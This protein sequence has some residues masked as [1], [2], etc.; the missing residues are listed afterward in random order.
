MNYKRL[1]PVITPAFVWGLSQV[2]F[3]RP[4]FFFAALALGTLLIAW[5]VKEIAGRHE[6]DWYFFISAPILFSLAFN[7]YAAVIASSFLVQVCFVAIAWFLYSYLK[8]FYHFAV[9]KEER[10][11]WKIRLHRL[12]IPGGFLTMFA[13]FAVMLYLP[14]FFNLDI[15][16]SLPL[17]IVLSWLLFVQFGPIKHI[18][19]RPTGTLVI[20]NVIIMAEMAWAFTLL[21]FNYNLLALFAAITYYLLLLI[22][23]LEARG[24]LNRQSLRPSLIIIVSAMLLLVLTARW[25]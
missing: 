9:H 11:D 2:F 17:F 4:L 5:S 21:P 19:A 14:L 23:R 20:I 8:A 10:E 6:P 16:I 15:Y 12:L 18:D 25:L 3:W 13:A 24:D 7:S 22:V 1:L